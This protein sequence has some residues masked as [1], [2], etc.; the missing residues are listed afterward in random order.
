ML[1]WWGVAGCAVVARLLPP[2][3]QMVS[4]DHLSSM[5]IWSEP[6]LIW[7]LRKLS[8]RVVA[9]V[10]L[11]GGAA[12]GAS[13]TP[14]RGDRA[15]TLRAFPPMYLISLLQLMSGIFSVLLR[16]PV[17]PHRL[18]TVQQIIMRNQSS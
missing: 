8:S 12:I 16:R 5:M 18:T 3:L 10:M 9:D 6:L 17:Y 14:S 15:V 2:E 11:Q 7:V 1:V 13:A 4:H